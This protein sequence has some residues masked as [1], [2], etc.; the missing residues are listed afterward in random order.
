MA[1]R[2][3]PFDTSNFTPDA[4]AAVEYGQ[5]TAAR[6]GSRY[7]TG[8]HLLLGSI[9]VTGSTA[10]RALDEAEVFPSQVWAALEIGLPYARGIWVRGVSAGDIYFDYVTAVASELDDTTIRPE[11]LFLATIKDTQERGLGS[12]LLDFGIDYSLALRLVRRARA[13]ETNSRRPAV[14]YRMD[15]AM[16]RA[17]HTVELTNLTE[18]DAGVVLL[19]LLE[20]QSC[21]A[22]RALKRA[23]VEASRLL[24]RPLSRCRRRTGVLA[25]LEELTDHGHDEDRAHA[26]FTANA[27]MTGLSDAAHEIAAAAGRSALRSDDMLLALLNEDGDVGSILKSCNVT[28]ERVSDAIAAMQRVDR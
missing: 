14:S 6:Y 1:D 22:Y 26:A 4:V 3:L 28:K 8:L 13:L 27:E 12:S 15:Q 16:R 11:H 7:L 17:V 24:S 25:L 21:L 9:E 5:A 2:E 23:G 10:P 19:G 18:I 20:E